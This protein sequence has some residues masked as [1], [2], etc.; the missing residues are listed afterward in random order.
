MSED[1]E[2]NS[3][4]DRGEYYTTPPYLSYTGTPGQERIQERRP[5]FHSS[6]EDEAS[7]DQPQNTPYP[8]S[9][10][11]SDR[12][13]QLGQGRTTGSNRRGEWPTPIDPFVGNDPY[14]GIDSCIAASV[15]SQGLTAT[16]G[17]PSA[18]GL[19]P[20]LSPTLPQDVEDILEQR[21]LRE[22]ANRS[23]AAAIAPSERLSVSR[24]T[25][26]HAGRDIRWEPYAR[27]SSAATSREPNVTDISHRRRP[28]RVVETYGSGSRPVTPPGT[29][30]ERGDEAY[31]IL[32][33]ST[34][35]V[36]GVEIS[37][38]LDSESYSEEN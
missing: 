6:D 17:G 32:P 4:A 33:T 30:L 35:T 26:R 8:V 19:P 36:T 18:H 11:M 9:D 14:A 23:S 38:Y 16:A 28:L 15:G 25:H 12:H 24:T 3:G 13:W 31:P 1:Q 7:F 5:V 20:L 22:D 34:D 27:S 37:Y 21:P 10:Y 2:G 29:C